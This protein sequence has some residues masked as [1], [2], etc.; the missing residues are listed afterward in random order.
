M[1]K[2]IC[3]ILFLISVTTISKA[4]DPIEI[5]PQSKTDFQITTQQDFLKSMYKLK[6]KQNNSENKMYLLENKLENL[7]EKLESIAKQIKNPKEQ[8]ALKALQEQLAKQTNKNT[9]IQ[10]TIAI[11]NF[12]IS[13]KAVIAAAI[14]IVLAVASGC[15]TPEVA[16][17]IAW[18]FVKKS[19]TICW[20]LLKQ[21]TKLSW[22]LGKES[23]KGVGKAFK[24]TG[25][26]Y[27]EDKAN[28]YKHD[29][30]SWLV[31]DKEKSL[32]G[33]NALYI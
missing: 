25:N 12:I 14:I 32:A 28:G 18:W 10:N 23:V 11:L 21:L 6:N 13:K 1:K 3:T 22:Y 5:L 7:T 19:L 17:K 20:W 4:S 29:F 16:I 24:E 9:K 8:I 27:K 33:V 26:M 30:Y 31:T 2:I 15:I